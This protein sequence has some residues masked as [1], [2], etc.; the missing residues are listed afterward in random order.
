MDDHKEFIRHRCETGEIYYEDPDIFYDQNYCLFKSVQA[1]SYFQPLEDTGLVE[2]LGLDLQQ[3]VVEILG[4]K[5]IQ[6]CDPAAQVFHFEP[7]DQVTFFF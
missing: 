7:V 5:H 1:N 6:T 3:E 2:D 4:K